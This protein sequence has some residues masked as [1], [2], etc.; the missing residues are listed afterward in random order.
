MN[1]VVVACRTLEDELRFAMK[2]TGIDYPVEWIESGLH[3]TPEILAE[4]LQGALDSIVAQR[5]LAVFGFCGN[6]MRGIKAGG[7]ELII[8]RV[9]DCISL[10]LGSVKARTEISG[11]HAA[12]FLTE[13]WIRGKRSLWAEYQYALEKYGEE[14]ALSLADMML[15]NYRT[16]GLLDSGVQPIEPLIEKTKIVADTLGLTQMVI[17]ATVSY[18]EELLTGP[19]VENRFL[20]KAPGETVTAGDLYLHYIFNDF[21]GNY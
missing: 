12:Y 21:S 5:V 11:K 1:T 4:R 7:F 14:Q 18:L 17:P 10:L 16:L 8:P 3:N 20:V 9:D 19:W 15:H 2:K 13:G 6:S